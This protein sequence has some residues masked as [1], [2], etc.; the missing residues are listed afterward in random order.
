ML[1]PQHSSALPLCQQTQTRAAERARAE[2]VVG[3]PSHVEVRTAALLCVAAAI[4]AALPFVGAHIVVWQLAVVPIAG[5]QFAAAQ[6]IAAGPCIAAALTATVRAMVSAQRLPALPSA[7]LLL[8]RTTTTLPNA[9]TPRI[10]P[11]TE[12]DEQ[13]EGMT[14]I[15]AARPRIRC[16][17][18]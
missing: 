4:V 11:A 16:S 18:H 2:P 17:L 3:P 1:L 15:G 5:R 6:S 14:A 12:T 9:D 7:R 13:R 8:G 10:H